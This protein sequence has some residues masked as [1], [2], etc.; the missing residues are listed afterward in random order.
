MNGWRGWP[1]WAPASG[2]CVSCQSATLPEGQSGSSVLDSD[3]L[4]L[5]RP[6]PDPKIN[7]NQP[8]TTAWA[9]AVPSPAWI[10]GSRGPSASRP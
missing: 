7:Q 8:S 9:A 2:R 5:A 6:G 4:K 10:S 1:V 3:S